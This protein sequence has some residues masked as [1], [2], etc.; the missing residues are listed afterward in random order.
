MV[1]QQ[2]KVFSKMKE[3]ITTKRRATIWHI[4]KHNPN[5]Y[6]RALLLNY[7]LLFLE[8]DLNKP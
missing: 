1:C 3:S 4:K 5:E 2:D 7:F 6:G 8:R